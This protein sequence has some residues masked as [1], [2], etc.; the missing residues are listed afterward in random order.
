M[1][2]DK[3]NEIKYDNYYVNDYEEDH[4]EHNP[5]PL[6]T[7]DIKLNQRG[8]SKQYKE[9]KE[10]KINID[11]MKRSSKDFKEIVKSTSKNKILS[12]ANAH[13]LIDSIFKD[14]I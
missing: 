6:I 9:G 5:T 7:N 14:K 2:L 3:I 10:A 11:R 13:K 1:H 12:E 8:R 4:E